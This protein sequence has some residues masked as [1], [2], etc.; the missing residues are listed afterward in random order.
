MKKTKIYFI[1]RKQGFGKRRWRLSHLE[2]RRRDESAGFRDAHNSIIQTRF[3]SSANVIWVRV[4]PEFTTDKEIE[5]IKKRIELER[6]NKVIIN[7]I[8]SFY[9]FDSKDRTFNNW[10][11]VGLKC[12]NNFSISLNQVLNNIDL[13]ITQVQEFINQHNKMFLRTNNETAANGMFVLN[14]SSSKENI[15]EKILLLFRRCNSFLYD[16]KDTKIVSVEFI[17][18]ENKKGYVDLYRVHILLGKI[19]SYYGVTTKLDIFHNVDMSIKDLDRFIEI[20]EKMPNI[21]AEFKQKILLG[22]K[23]L[24][25]NIGA[26]EFFIKNGEPIFIEFNPMWGGH[27]S[28]NGFGNNEVQAYLIK[29]EELLKTR[30]PN[31]YEFLNYR[32][33]YQKLYE[34]IH[35]HITS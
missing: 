14:N 26:I 24:G 15:K 8:N 23:S 20:N 11:K 3:I 35:S 7:D 9:N 33:Y 28:K 32:K 16:R 10:E 31:I 12:P 1:G 17:K 27:A 5:R 22:A 6:K 4:R 29:N 30:I 18:P 19:I 2:N 21:I 34:T 25:C 13:V